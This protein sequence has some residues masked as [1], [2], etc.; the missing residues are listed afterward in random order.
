MWTHFHSHS[1]MMDKCDELKTLF[2]DLDE[3][4]VGDVG[5][6]GFLAGNSGAGAR[7]H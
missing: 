2:N 5:L 6:E 1:R 7:V 3:T 4:L